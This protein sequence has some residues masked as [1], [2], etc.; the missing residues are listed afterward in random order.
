MD[1]TEKLKLENC[2]YQK[3][4]IDAM[5]RQVQSDATIPYRTHVVPGVI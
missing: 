3:D 2:I 5:F 4:V 1:L